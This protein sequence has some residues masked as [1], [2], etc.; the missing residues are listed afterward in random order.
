MLELKPEELVSEIV[1]LEADIAAMGAFI[2]E[3]SRKNEQLR[4]EMELAEKSGNS[5]LC[6]QIEELKGQMTSILEQRLKKTI[7]GGQPLDFLNNIVN[8]EKESS[9]KLY[10]MCRLFRD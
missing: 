6:A 3:L 1:G 2:T 4:I 8:L 7:T 9:M 5:A 10:A